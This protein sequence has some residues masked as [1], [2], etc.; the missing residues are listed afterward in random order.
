MPIYAKIDDVTNL[1]PEELVDEIYMDDPDVIFDVIKKNMSVPTTAETKSEAVAALAQER[2]LEADDVIDGYLSAGAVRGAERG[3]SL[4]QLVASLVEAAGEVAEPHE[5]EA[6][7][8]L[9][10]ELVA[11]LDAR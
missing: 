9:L 8:A 11:K 7:A 6:I 3:S 4:R 1:S 10:R 2:D 5:R